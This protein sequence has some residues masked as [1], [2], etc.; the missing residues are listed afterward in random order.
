MVKSPR[1][2]LGPLPLGRGTG[3]AM[4]GPLPTTLAL[5]GSGMAL[6]CAWAAPGR[7][8]AALCARAM[9]QLPTNN[10]AASLNRFIVILVGWSGDQEG[11]EIGIQRQTDLGLVRLGDLSAAAAA[12]ACR[13]ARSGRIGAH[14]RIF[15]ENATRLH[16]IFIGMRQG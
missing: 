7:D 2:R 14:D 10:A 9:T 4:I 6:D 11:F 8:G 16:H 15:R 13:R 3:G 1:G 5:A 12:A